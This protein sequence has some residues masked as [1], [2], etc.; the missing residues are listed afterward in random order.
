MGTPNKTV[1]DL[2]EASSM[3]TAFTSE[4]Q[5]SIFEH[6]NLLPSETK[7]LAIHLNPS[8]GLLFD[9]LLSARSS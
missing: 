4:P 3:C 1:A 5:D 6:L 9:D 7:G 8:G 2:S